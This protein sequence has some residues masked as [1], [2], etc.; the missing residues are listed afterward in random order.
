MKSSESPYKIQNIVATGRFPKNWDI[1]SLYEKLN[2]PEKSYEPETYP[3]LL[4]KVQIPTGRRHV[5]LYS[6]GKFIIA[7]A[8][9]EDELAQIYEEIK[10]Q[11]KKVGAI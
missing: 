9:S 2:V 6:N 4:V 7:G 8:R 1:V 3:A 11:L 5:T 10:R